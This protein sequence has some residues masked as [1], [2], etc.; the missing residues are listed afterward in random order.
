[1]T[2]SAQMYSLLSGSTSVTSQ[3]GTRVYPVTLPQDVRFPAVRYTIVSNIREWAMTD[4]TGDVTAR[5]QI[6]SWGRTPDEAETVSEGVRAAV[7]RQVG[8]VEA[9]SVPTSSGTSVRLDTRDAQAQTFK[10]SR[11]L[12]LSSVDVWLKRVGSPTGSISCELW[13]STSGTFGTSAIPTTLLETSPTTHNVANISTASFVEYG[14]DFPTTT[15]STGTVYALAARYADGDIS[16]YVRV[17]ATS[18][19]TSHPGNTAQAAPTWEN[20]NAFD[21]RHRV[22]AN[23]L[24]CFLENE[25]VDYDDSTGVYAHSLDVIVHYTE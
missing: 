25:L 15:L 16:N 20:V 17:D 4:D 8:H 5:V 13:R 2:L 11:T 6:T 18:A 14:F 23:G 1:M 7:Q 12:F 19:S 9:S 21:L 10:V 3:V 24:E 22:T